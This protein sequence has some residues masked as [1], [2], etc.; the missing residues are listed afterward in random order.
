MTPLARTAVGSVAAAEAVVVDLAL[1]GSAA[2]A[3]AAATAAAVVVEAKAEPEVRSGPADS[4][5][6]RK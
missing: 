5:V 2:A 1:V 6:A 3:M 4:M